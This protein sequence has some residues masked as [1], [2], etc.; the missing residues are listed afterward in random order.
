MVEKGNCITSLAGDEPLHCSNKWTPLLFYRTPHNPFQLIDSFLCRLKK[1]GIFIPFKRS[2]FEVSFT[3]QRKPCCL[4]YQIFCDLNLQILDLFYFIVE[5]LH[6]RHGNL[7][8][9]SLK[10]LEELYPT[11]LLKSTLAGCI[12]R[13]EIK[14][15]KGIFMLF[16]PHADDEAMSMAEEEMYRNIG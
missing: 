5:A 1:F 3:G 4:T 16:G 15:G 8:V 14:L 12:F 10:L 7:V 9:V 13:A 2:S 11:F 6:E